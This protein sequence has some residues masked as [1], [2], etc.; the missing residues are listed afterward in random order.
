MSEYPR[1][2]VDLKKFRHNVDEMTKL[3]EAN[4]ISVAGVIKGYSGIP[5]C[6]I[7]FERGG[8]SFIASSRLEQLRAARE[9]GIK[10]PLMAIRPPMI[11]EIQE[12]VEIAEYSLNSEIEVLKLLNEEAKKQGKIHNVILMVDLGDLREGFWDKEEF[13]KAGLLVENDLKN[14]HL[15]GTGTNLGCYGSIVA[16]TEKLEELVD[17]TE[18]LE[19]VIGRRVEYISGGGSTSTPRL[20]E[21]NMPER[22]NHLRIGEAILLAKDMEEQYGYDY[23]FMNKDVFVLEAEVIEVRDK[24][25]HPVGEIGYDSFGNKEVYEDRGIRKRALIGIGKVDY[26]F[27]DKIYPREE[28]I[29][30]L[31]AS[32]D[33]TILDVEN[34]KR[35]IK[36]GDVV[37]FDVSYATMVFVTNTPNVKLKFI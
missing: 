29:E 26:A 35:D 7:E 2:R 14:L 15:A 21:K 20:L 18:E 11:S 32:S 8:V 4:G 3:C 36:L 19:E 30:V 31:G 24:P 10:V 12:V 6:T 13:L 25:S 33:H 22:I 34:M 28:G 1:L 16:T 37:A 5:E 17:A 27:T 23:S 9:A